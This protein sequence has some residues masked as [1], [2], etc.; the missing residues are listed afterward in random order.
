M[1]GVSVRNI[2]TLAVKMETVIVIG[3]SRENLTY[4]VYRVHEINSKILFLSRHFIIG[5][6]LRY[7]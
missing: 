6:C 5:G 2:R 3:K 4:F 1:V 7:G